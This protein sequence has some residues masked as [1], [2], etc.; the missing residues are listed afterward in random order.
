VLLQTFTRQEDGQDLA[1]YG[2]LVALIALL[3][4]A[5]VTGLGINLLDYWNGLA[6]RRMF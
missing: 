4:F 3:V 1:E 6:R 5:G 2:L